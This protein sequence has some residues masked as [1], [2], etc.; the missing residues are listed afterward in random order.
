MKQAQPPE[1]INSHNVI[2][3]NPSAPHGQAREAVKDIN[4]WVDERTG[5]WIASYCASCVTALDS[6]AALALPGSTLTSDLG[7]LGEASEAR[8]LYWDEDVRAAPILRVFLHCAI[9][10]R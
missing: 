3:V 5:A 9:I 10:P 6:G 8:K 2:T 1:E 4:P 7:A